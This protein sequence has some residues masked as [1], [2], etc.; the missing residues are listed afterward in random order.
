MKP[1]IPVRAI[2]CLLLS[3]SAVWLTA[4]EKRPSAPAEGEKVIIP[5]ADALKPT[6]AVPPSAD[7]APTDNATVTTQAIAP[8]PPPAAQ[9]GAN[10][11][12]S[13]EQPHKLKIPPFAQQAAQGNAFRLRFLAT[14]ESFY[15]EIKLEN[16]ILSYTYF[17]DTDN[18]CAQWIQSAPCWRDSD[19]KTISMALKDEDLDNLY[20][21]A[22][23]SGVLKLSREAYGGARQGQR[24]YA[25]RLEVGLD[26]K[27]KTVVYQHFPGAAQKPEAFARLET[28]LVEY[29]RDLPH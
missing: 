29:A 5:E 16:G 12:A 28:A 15:T 6:P 23:D 9:P 2:C 11:S 24:Y 27:R 25:Q 13:K 20:S 1:N 10:M 4:C 22:K 21:V 7:S 26:G 17:E 8:A 14:G 19:L 18:R 3:L